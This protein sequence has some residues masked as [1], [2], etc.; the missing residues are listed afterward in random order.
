M[1]VMLVG[2][3]HNSGGTGNSSNQAVSSGD[4]TPTSANPSNVTSVTP[5]VFDWI[6]VGNEVHVGGNVTASITTGGAVA[7]FEITLPIAPVTSRVRGTVISAQASAGVCADAGGNLQVYIPA[8]F[9]VA[10]SNS[11]YLTAIYK[12]N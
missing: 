3:L 8:A 9:S 7:N 2:S 5:G 6:R 1:G 11:F 4:Y 10:G 12:V